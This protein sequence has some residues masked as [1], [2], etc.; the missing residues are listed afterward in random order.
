MIYHSTHNNPNLHTFMKIPKLKIHNKVLGELTTTS[1]EKSLNIIETSINNESGE[2]FAK[3]IYVLE[4]S[5]PIAIGLSIN[6]EPEYINKGNNFGEILR[7]STIIT[8]LENKLK[9]FQIYSKNSA[10]YFHS[11]YK[12]V[13]QLTT[14]NQR[15]SM[16]KSILFNCKDC[17]P[18]IREEADILLKKAKKFQAGYPQENLTEQV[19]LLLK[20]YIEKVLQSPNEY[21]K[22]GFNTGINMTLTQDRI[23]E[24][25]DFFNKLF[26]KHNIDYRI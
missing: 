17:Y 14:I 26:E 24:N 18:E 9:E 21:T 19:N 15:I 20:N 23:L 3:E 6:V 4:D 8:I 16:L 13:P 10:I 25:K 7:L 22:H 1:V 2:R 12:F 5:N 11:K